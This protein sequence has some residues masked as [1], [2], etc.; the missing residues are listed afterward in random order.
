MLA[1]LMLIELLNMIFFH[2]PWERFLRYEKFEKV[3][4]KLGQVMGKYLFLDIILRK[5]PFEK[6]KKNWTKM[7]KIRRL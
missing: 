1:E 5:I 3:W 2:N 7:E 6:Y 4:K